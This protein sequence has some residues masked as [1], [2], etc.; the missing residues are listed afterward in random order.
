LI[1]ERRYTFM[2]SFKETSSSLVPRNMGIRSMGPC[3]S[4]FVGGSGE[5]S[6]IIGGG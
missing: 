2:K 6:G 3:N 5:G 4:A 1:V